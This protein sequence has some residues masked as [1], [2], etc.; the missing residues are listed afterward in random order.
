MELDKV[1]D[2][3][4]KQLEITTDQLCSKSKVREVSI[5]RNIYIYF[6]LANCPSPN[7]VARSIGLTTRCVNMSAQN[8]EERIKYDRVFTYF[9]N[10][11]KSD[12]ECSK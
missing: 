12:I 2:I 7:I 6:A 11:V 1:K 4:C 5:A 9:F 8:I 10:V 3:V